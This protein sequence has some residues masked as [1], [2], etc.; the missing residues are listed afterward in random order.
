VYGG[1]SGTKAEQN[2]FREFKEKYTGI[3]STQ[4]KWKDIVE[5]TKKLRIP[6]GLIFY[7]PD[8]VWQGSDRNPY[9]KNTTSICNYPVQSFAT[10]DIIPIAVVIMQ[11]L[12]KEKEL[13]SFIVN[14][15]HDSIIMEVHPAEVEAVEELGRYA[16]VY[17]V[18]E[19]L[20]DVY[21]VE[22]NVPL[23]IE[24]KFGRYW[25]ERDG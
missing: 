21:D 17:G 22:F 2:Y 15:I 3:T 4:E 14:T 24:A 12:L 23:D 11:G 10:A 13:E 6:S 25:N 19:Y 5:R 16:F 18:V 9:L 20:K 8:T 7:W 1:L